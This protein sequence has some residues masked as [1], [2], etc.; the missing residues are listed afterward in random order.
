[1]IVAGMSTIPSRAHT[2]PLA[3]ASLLPQVDRLWLSLDGY[4]AIPAFA[5][6]PKIICQF[7]QQ[8]GG[9]KAEGKFLGLALDDDAQ[10]YVSADDDMLYPK[11]FVRHLA[12]MCILHP[13]PVA[14]GTHGSVFKK[15]IRSY[16][17]DRKVTMSRHSQIRPWRKVDVLA[18]NGT[19]HLV[20]DLKF[21]CR[22]WIY[23]NQVDLNFL[24]EASKQDVGLVTAMRRR[25]W[26]RPLETRQSNSIYANLLKDDSVQTSRIC[27]ILGR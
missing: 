14:V 12:R 6:H 10:I 26:T 19:V 11:G 9:L 7:G 15:D 3:I 2:S 16:V 13:K 20:K 23:R 1:M 8:H 4:E 22:N 21:D 5:K 24:E 25:S 27:K 17:S 18:T